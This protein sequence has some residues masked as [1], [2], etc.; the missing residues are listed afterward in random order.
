MK[1][2]LIVSRQKVG[3]LVRPRA[4]WN[5]LDPEVL[6]WH[7]ESA[8]TDAYV[9]GLFEVRLIVEPAATFIAAQR[10][11]PESV[12]AMQSALADMTRHQHSP[13][14]LSAAD[15]RFHQA[16][17]DATGNYF[18]ASLGAVIENA[19]MATFRL[20][21]FGGKQ[22][23]AFSLRQHEEVMEAIRDGRAEE[24]RAI[25]TDLLHGAIEDVRAA[26]ARREAA[27]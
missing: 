4:E 5:M 14:E 15:L 17:L 3:T 20:S 2:R 13:P 8:P 23:P 22:A 10:R 12:A 24:A 26:L 25:M 1:P 7:L 9:N 21:W 11:T 6:G 18:L 16:I 19:L 27:A